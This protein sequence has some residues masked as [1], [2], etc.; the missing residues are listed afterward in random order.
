MGRVTGREGVVWEYSLG[1]Q[2]VVLWKA[3]HVSPWLQQSATSPEDQRGF[4]HPVPQPD[5]RSQSATEMPRVFFFH[6]CCFSLFFHCNLTVTFQLCNCAPSYLKGPEAEFCTPL[7]NMLS[8]SQPCTP[9]SGSQPQQLLW[10]SYEKQLL[11]LFLSFSSSSPFVFW[12]LMYNIMLRNEH[13]MNNMN[14]L[15]AANRR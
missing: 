6:L 4:Y 10:V 12:L 14:C 15:V 2:V 9:C 5:Q 11:P 13:N 8:S 3:L 1:A 7:S